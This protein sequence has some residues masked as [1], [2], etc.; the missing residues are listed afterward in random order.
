MP[1][2]G[3]TDRC[4]VKPE[5]CR[6]QNLLQARRKESSQFAISNKKQTCSS[7]LST[8]SQSPSHS[9]DMLPQRL[10]GHLSSRTSTLV[11]TSSWTKDVSCCCNKKA[12]LTLLVTDEL[13]HGEKCPDHEWKQILN[14]VATA[15]GMKPP[16]INEDRNLRGRELYTASWCTQKC[17]D[18]PP[19]LCAIK[20][21]QCPTT[22]KYYKCP[23][24]RR[25]LEKSGKG[26][27]KLPQHRCQPWINE[28]EKKLDVL[29][30]DFHDG[31]HTLLE[32]SREYEC[33][34]TK[35]I[36]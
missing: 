34:T 36:Q 28:I 23:T 31:C 20:H 12:N 14:V 24:G 13:A 18:L 11:F 35:Q 6:G 10:A 9:V 16:S 17:C 8:L 5:L 7:L 30:E 33:F 22:I 29:M 2:Q 27:R 19:H 15:G 1:K 3:Q 4:T 21:W 32:A 25:S 26:P